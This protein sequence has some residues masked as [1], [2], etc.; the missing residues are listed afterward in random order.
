M[1]DFLGK[2]FTRAGVGGFDLALKLATCGYEL[3]AEIDA[4]RSEHFAETNHLGSQVRAIG[5]NGFA[6]FGDTVGE[7]TNLAP[8]L[9]E[10]A[11]YFL[12]Q[13]IEPSAEPGDRLQHQFET[14]A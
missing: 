6:I 12:A 5:R 10:L 7:K 2:P 11:G 8:D 13:Y 9:S 14:S 3:F 1:G 4:R